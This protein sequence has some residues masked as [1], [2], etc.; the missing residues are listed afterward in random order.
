MMFVTNKG[1]ITCRTT[2][3][4]IKLSFTLFAP[5]AAVVRCV[6]NVRSKVRY[7]RHIYVPILL[8]FY[9]VSSCGKCSFLR[10]KYL[11]VTSDASTGAS[12]S[13]RGSFMSSVNERDAS[14]S[15]S[16]EK[17]KFDPCAC[18]CAYSYA[19]VEAIFTVK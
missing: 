18:A 9:W 8:I 4:S 5:I 19:C 16:Q 14:T 11:V 13:I 6:G 17:E 10:L 7:A 15:P 12:T 3:L 1:S 2:S